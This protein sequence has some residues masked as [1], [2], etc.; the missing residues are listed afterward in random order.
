MSLLS[1]VRALSIG[2]LLAVDSTSFSQIVLPTPNVESKLF[3]ADSPRP[4]PLIVGFGG[5]EGGN[6]W[7]S[8]YWKGT[9]DEFLRRGYAFLAIGYFKSPGTP[10]TLDKIPIDL[11]HDAIVEASKNTAVDRKRI[12]VIGGSR[13]GDLA[14][15]IGSHY[16]DIKCVVAIVPSHVVFPGNTAPLA[17]SA[18][19]F[20]GKELPYVPVTQ[21]AMPSILKRDLRSAFEIMLKN[22]AKEEV[23]Q[24]QVEKVNGPI[25]FMSATKDEVCPST[26]MCEKM[27]ARLKSKQFRHPSE[28]VAVDGS[29]AAPL[30]HFDQVLDFLDKY[31]PTAGRSQQRASEAGSRG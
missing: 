21:E 26:P 22:T 28:H 17:S 18:W 3:L 29:H 25:L 14:L 10:A 5:S 12:C 8:N 20:K 1:P 27:M 15:L 7:A 30:K 6:A 11:V 23:A 9:R 24:I 4:Q 19:T 13:G 2:L 16:Q 31:F